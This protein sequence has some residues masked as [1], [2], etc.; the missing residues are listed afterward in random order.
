MPPVRRR[1]TDTDN[2]IKSA[3][4]ATVAFVFFGALSFVG[5]WGVSLGTT[6]AKLK[7]DIAVVHEKQ[8]FLAP[9]LVDEIKGIRNDMKEIRQELRALATF[10]HDIKRK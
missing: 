7:E 8:E 9:W 6:V 5:T 3:A 2:I 1:K 4:K 10:Q